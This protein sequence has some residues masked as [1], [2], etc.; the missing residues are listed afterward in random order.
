MSEQKPSSAR[1]FGT[2]RELTQTAAATAM[3][4]F[5]SSFD[6]EVK[7]GESPATTADS[8]ITD[9]EGQPLDFN[10][11]GRAISAATPEL[12]GEVLDLLSEGSSA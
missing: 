3:Q 11:D 9:W 8:S 5:R 1:I 2:A 4:Y 6:I 7:G 10:S 12:R